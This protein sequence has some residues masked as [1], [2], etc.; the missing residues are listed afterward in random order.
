IGIK[1]QDRELL[2]PVKTQDRLKVE[3]ILK[4]NGFGDN[5]DFVVIHPAASC[6][7]KRW[8]SQ[9]FALVADEIVNKL[10][11]KI[12][13]V[14]SVNGK[15]C[16]QDIK[17]AE[18]VVL[19][20]SGNLSIGELAALLQKAKLL[21]SNDSGPVHIAVAL[22]VPVVA[23]GR[24]QPG[25]SFKRWGPIGKNDII[26]H[27]DV[28]CLECLAHNCKVGFKCLMAIEPGEVIEAAR[29]LLRL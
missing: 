16:G 13:I 15:G 8:P 24:K 28:G 10:H 1:S 7:S 25:L 2:V 14:A 4:E 18:K 20:L 19:D 11:K 29:K 5:E 26:L 23:I 6:P 27:K 21:I 3:N 22:K 17:S 12:V 9:R